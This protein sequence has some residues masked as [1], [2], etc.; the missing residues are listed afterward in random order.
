M[1]RTPIR[2]AVFLSLCFLA[3]VLSFLSVPQSLPPQSQ[4]AMNSSTS[5]ALSAL[6]FWTRSRAYPEPDIPNDKFYRSY[7]RSKQD[8]RELLS[9]ESS[10]AW[11]PIG[12][13]NI[14]GRMISIAVNPLNPNTIYAGSASGGLWRS[15]TAG[16]GGDWHRVKTGFPVLGVMAIAINPID[17][18]ILYIGT[19]ETYGYER[20][21][22]GFVIRT[23]RGSYGIGILK[24]T[25]GGSSWTKSL[26]WS[27]QQQRGVQAIRLNPLN[28]S[29][30]FAATTEGIYRSRDA[31]TSWTLVMDVPM[32]EDVVIHS[33]DT[34]RVMVSCGNLGSPNAGVYVSLD[35]G[36]L[37]FGCTLPQFSGKT[38]LEPFAANPDVV[39]A[40]VADSLTELEQGVVHGL[41]QTTDFGASW[42]RLHSR[43]VPLYQGW[44]SHFVAVH[45]TDSLRVVHAGVSLTK[46]YDGGR[47]IAFVS[48]VHADNHNYAHDP[49]D[50][51]ILYVVGDGGV[52]RSTNFGDT[53]VPLNNGLQTAQFYNGF[54]S[55]A[56][57]SNVAMGGLQD[58]GTIIYYGN[59]SD[60]KW[61]IGGDGCWTAIDPTNDY[62]MYGEFQYN[63]ILRSLTRGTSF[64]TITNGMQNDF[65][66]AFVAPFVLAPSR[67]TRLYSGRTDVYL[68]DDRGDN[69]Y[70]T[71][72]GGILDGNSVLSL[73]VAPS[74]FNIVYAGTAPTVTRAHIFRSTTGGGNWADVTDGLPDRYPMDIA[75][76]PADPSIVYVVFGG[77]GSGHIFSSTN[78][79]TTWSD[80]TGTLPD[81]PT[82]SIAIDP[83]NTRHLYLGN[84]FGVYVSTDRGDSWNLFSDGLSDAVIAMDL[85]ISPRDRRLRVATHG[86]GAYQRKLIHEGP[87]VAEEEPMLPSDFGLRPN[88]PNPFNPSTT[89]EYQMKV[90]GFVSIQVFDARGREVAVLV[91]EEKPAGSHS[92]R[93][94]AGGLAS[95]VYFVKMNV[96][97]NSGRVQ[98]RSAIK[99]L[100][101]H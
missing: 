58:N 62:V 37:W 56:Q 98:F 97:D 11:E 48:G 100:I 25:D 1:H 82:L 64:A 8:I 44:F 67:P 12:P 81:V 24:S 95:G 85:S 51:E 19:G 41:W 50:P 75:I 16:A 84:D 26:D 33:A 3:G 96:S 40:S 5:G 70:P 31:G 72:S 22:G 42:Q 47:H 57:D 77:F 78:G 71:S 29:T 79:G 93:W 21:I 91:N 36:D 6:R 69:W 27:Y 2:S 4:P 65:G 86:N 45:P 49:V 35:A 53:Y 83:A 99:S 15:H 9:S 55:S 63:I 7:I 88:Y 34:T 66:A 80:V 89:I 20:S 43:D 68:T 23:T 73:V 38:L 94:D 52:Y 46:S 60:W 10:S 76:D 14:A 59:P 101:V 74:N 61:R 54:S 32:G 17:T 18:N 28:P 39:F 30:I 90:A 13:L 87:V 92:L